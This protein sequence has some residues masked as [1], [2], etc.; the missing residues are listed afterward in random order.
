MGEPEVV[1]DAVHH[2]VNRGRH[3]AAVTEV[4]DVELD[5]GAFDPDEWIEAVGLD[6]A[7]Q[8]QSW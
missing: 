5:E 3:G 8:R 6:H 2:R 4:A 7:N 1:A